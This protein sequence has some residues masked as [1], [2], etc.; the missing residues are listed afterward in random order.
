MIHKN[1]ITS[2][3]YLRIKNKHSQLFERSELSIA[4]GVKRK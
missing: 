2:E 3:A 4:A 1:E